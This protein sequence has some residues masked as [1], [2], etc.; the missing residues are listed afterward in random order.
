MRTQMGMDTLFEDS[1]KAIIEEHFK[2]QL[3]MFEMRCGQGCEGIRDD[4]RVLE[5]GRTLGRSVNG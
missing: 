5:L 4:S 3:K 2:M 1:T